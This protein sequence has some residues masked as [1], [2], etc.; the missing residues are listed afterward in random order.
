[1]EKATQDLRKEHSSILHALKIYDD[2]M[3]SGTR[4][5]S[6]MLKYYG[7]LIYFL[8]VFADKCHHGKEEGY[9][10]KS[11][12]IRE[13]VRE[14]GFIELLL[15]EH[16]LAREYVANMEKALGS[17]DIVE[18][19]SFAIKYRDLL[20]KHIEEENNGIFLMA[21][22]VLSEEEQDLLFEQF[23]EHEEKVIGQGV[24]EELHAMIHEWEAL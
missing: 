2:I 17:K 15:E 22:E 11:L 8:Q 18:F 14:T 6:V 12:T 20:R 9:L 21:E 1:M 19:N 7:E 24:H 4:D 3:S 16:A 10:F 23:E 13:D 5:E